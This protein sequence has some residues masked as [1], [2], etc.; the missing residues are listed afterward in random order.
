[1][2]SKKNARRFE[3]RVTVMPRRAVL[4]PQ[5]KAIQ[6]ALGRLGMKNVESLRAGKVFV[7]TVTGKDLEDARARTSAMA[8]KLLANPI[9]EDWTVEVEPASADAAEG[10]AT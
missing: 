10:A 4:D 9:M 1:M 6:Q 7:L 5:G 8:E 3:A 2:S